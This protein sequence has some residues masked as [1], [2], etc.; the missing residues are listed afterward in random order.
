ML[1]R[2]QLE[3]TAK[4]R[5]FL[6]NV[7]NPQDDKKKRKISNILSF[8]RTNRYHFVF[9]PVNMQRG[10]S[11]EICKYVSTK[12]SNL[13]ARDFNVLAGHEIRVVPP[14]NCIS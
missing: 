11:K 6:I 8:Y 10:D 2:I 9:Q 1:P 14:V 12:K 7:N 13:E 3:H 5:L 4:H